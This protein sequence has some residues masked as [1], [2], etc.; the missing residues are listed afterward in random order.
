MDERRKKRLTAAVAAV[1][2][3]LR[4]QEEQQLAME[5]VS[6][7]VSAPTVGAA[8]LWSASGRQAMM[9][10]RKLLQLRVMR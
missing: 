10:M 1:Y 9:E 4:S 6:Q 5:A 7:A 8:G 3:Y 2:R